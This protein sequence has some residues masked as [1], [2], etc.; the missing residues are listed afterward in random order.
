MWHSQD[1]LAAIL[2]GV[3]IDAKPG[4]GPDNKAQDSMGHANGT[5]LR[6]AVAEYAPQVAPGGWL[7]ITESGDWQ[8][9][10]EEFVHAVDDMVPPDVCLLWVT[11]NN[12]WVPDINAASVAA[13]LTSWH[14]CVAWDRWDL[15]DTEGNSTDGVHL[16]P[17]F[18]VLYAQRIVEAMGQ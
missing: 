18:E 17:D 4:R 10:T 5:T 3:M 15:Q 1:D 8:P 14:P 6:E 16:K 13:M 7:I 11:P 2:L 9:V 12:I